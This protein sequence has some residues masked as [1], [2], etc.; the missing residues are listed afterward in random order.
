MCAWLPNSTSRFDRGSLQASPLNAL[1]RMRMH[2]DGRLGVE[3][4][5]VGEREF[6]IGD[7]VVARRNDRRAGVVN[8]MRAEVVAIDPERRTVSLRSDH[9]DERT[10]TSAYL[11]EGWL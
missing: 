9:G 6:A 7:R 10:V 4:V 3:E 5:A 2:R 11:D 8:G 1:A